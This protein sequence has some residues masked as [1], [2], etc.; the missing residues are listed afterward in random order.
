AQQQTADGRP[1]E[2]GDTV[3]NGGLAGPVGADDGGNLAR[4]ADKGD[5]VDGN[6]AAE[7]HRK[8][9]DLD[10]WCRVGAHPLPP[11]PIGCR[12]TEGSRWAIRP[13]GRNTMISTMASPNAS[14]R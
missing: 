5:I 11:A 14:M 3:E 6:Q 7:A 12:R 8:V 9:R 1:V 4:T 2:A 10:Q 13:R